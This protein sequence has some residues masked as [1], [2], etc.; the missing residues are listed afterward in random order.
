M[1]RTAPHNP[2]VVR[3]MWPPTLTVQV[4]PGIRGAR[5][6]SQYGRA[7]GMGTRVLALI[8]LARST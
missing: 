6:P 2:H 4:T 7:L 3:T 5:H 1:R 8:L